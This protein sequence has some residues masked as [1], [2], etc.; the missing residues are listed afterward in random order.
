VNE[1][2]EANCIDETLI[3]ANDWMVTS[4]E[5]QGMGSEYLT[6]MIKSIVDTG[7]AVDGIV[8]VR[9]GKLVMEAYRKPYHSQEP[10]II[11]SCTKAFTSALLGIAMQEKYI[12]DIDQKLS[13][14][15][16]EGEFGHGMGETT[17]RHLLTMSSGMDIPEYEES[18][19]RQSPNWVKF[20]LSRA[21][22]KKPG[23]HFNY[24]DAGAHLVMAAI[25]RATGKD[26]ADYARKKI[27]GPL[28]I[29]DYY[30]ETDPQG[31]IEGGDGVHLKPRDMAK[32]GLL[33]LQKGCWNGQEIVPKQWVKESTRKQIATP[34]EMLGT[35]GYGFFWWMEEFGGFSALGY[36]GQYIFI[37]PEADLTVAFTC[38]LADDFELPRRMMKQFILPSIKSNQAINTDHKDHSKALCWE[39]E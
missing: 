5:K 33:Y 8:I 17:L 29:T 38:D 13:N 30:W 36:A 11:Y 12:A 16:P 37:A 24:N 19:M 22:V 1:L 23:S 25:A 32:M 35:H 14:L 21:I 28:G 3:S 26:P 31:L 7:K 15:L 6:G 27:L 34:G 39:I 2:I 9:H 20:A 18:E 10:H 4:P